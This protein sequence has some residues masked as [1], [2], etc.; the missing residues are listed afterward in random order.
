MVWGYWFLKFN[1]TSRCNCILFTV[2]ILNL[3]SGDCMLKSYAHYKSS[4]K[5]F[6]V[7]VHI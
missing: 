1:S 2:Q 3:D 7:Q 4:K 5:S 6:D